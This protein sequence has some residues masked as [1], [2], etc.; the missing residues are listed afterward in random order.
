[1]DSYDLMALYYNI[2]ICVLAVE[3]LSIYI[4]SKK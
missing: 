2:R 1:V 3:Y 4:D